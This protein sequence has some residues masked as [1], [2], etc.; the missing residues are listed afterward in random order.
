MANNKVTIY[1]HNQR[2]RFLA[3]ENEDYLQQCADIVNKEMDNAMDG[4][5]LSHH[6]RGGAGGHERGGQIL[7]GAAGLGQPAGPAEAGPGRK[8]PAGKGDVGDEAGGPQG[9]P[10]KRPRPSGKPRS[11]PKRRRRARQRRPS[12]ALPR[13]RKPR[14]RR[15]PDGTAGPCRVPGGPGRGRC[16]GG[17]DA[18]YLGFGPLNARRN[19]KN[20]TEE[21]LEEAVA[22]CHLRGVRVYLTLNTLL[23]NRELALAA[24]TGALAA[25]LGIERDPGPGPGRGEAPAGDLPG[26]AAARLHPDDGA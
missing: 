17:A 16:R 5:T 14:R 2:Y 22:Y 25:R 15:A 13:P 3:E 18:V 10:R 19:A 21:Q 4:N 26:C 11:R 24:E 9:P 6:R 23:Q 1:I 20:F 12:P 8:R 7:Q